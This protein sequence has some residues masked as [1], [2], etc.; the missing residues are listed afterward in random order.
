MTNWKKYITEKVGG[1]SVI[2]TLYKSIIFHDFFIA[3]VPLFQKW[4]VK[5]I[6]NRQRKTI[7]R[8]KAKKNI[9][10]LFF[11]QTPSVWKYDCLYRL[12]EKS[13]YFEPVVVIS[14]FNVHLIYDRQECLRVMRVT[15]NFVREQ[16]YNYISSYDFSQHKW[17]NVKK[18]LQPDVVFFTKPYKDTLPQYHIYNYP[19]CLTLYVPYGI[20]CMNL[21]KNNYGLPFDN[22]LWKL[23]VETDFQKQ[24]AHDYQLC[25][26]D[27]VEVVGAIA[28]EKL[29]NQDYHPKDVWK[30]QEKKK[31]RIIWA[32]HHTIDYLF[33]F[34]NFLE[35]AQIM[36]ELAVQYRDQIQV[37]F[38]PHPVLKFKL[39]NLWGK[40]KTEEYY[41]QW[42]EL[43]NGQL[44]EGEYMDLFATSDAMIHD[45]GSFTVEYLYTQK[46]VLFQVKHNDVANQWN[47]FGLK[48]FDCH[49]HGFSR[50]DLTHFIQEVVIN[51]NDTLKSQRK[52]L[53]NDYLYPKDG[54]LPSQKIYQLLA[55]NL[56]K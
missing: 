36:L 21:W 14:P 30:H 27:N 5:S 37:A 43:E 6:R 16:G 8:L 22:L 54:I 12:L 7:E 1:V 23:L 42:V 52:Q 39:I 49:Y 29:I 15:E 56:L 34:S 19:D 31:K 53:Y 24:Y 2:D 17:L 45:S 46:P 26:G 51:G 48:C 40:E 50:E 33:N 38:K 18:L 55:S 10:V 9:K 11:L 28:L 41:Q 32:P 35:Y 44:V 13:E 4:Y 3:S 25:K 20:N 47:T